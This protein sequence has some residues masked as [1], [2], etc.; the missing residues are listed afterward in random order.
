MDALV[1][2]RG[3]IPTDSMFRYAGNF[4]RTHAQHKANPEDFIVEE[5]P[6]RG[7]ATTVSTKSDFPCREEL[8]AGK[9]RYIAFTLVLLKMT[10]SAGVKAVASALG[11]EPSKITV[12]GNKDRTARTSQMAVVEIDDLDLVRRNSFP[13]ENILRRHGWFIK[14]VRRTDAS[15]SKGQLAGNRFH[16]KLLVPGMDKAALSAYL[17]VRLKHLL[18]V[19]DDKGNVPYI[20]NFFGRQRLGRRQ[21]L[22]GVGHTLI[23]EGL[24][25]GIK[26]FLCEAVEQNDHW[27]ATKL[28]RQLLPM[29][30]DAENLAAKNGGAVAEQ[31]YSFMDMREAMEV[32]VPDP[33]D[34]ERDRSRRRKVP[35]YR[36]A[37][38][39]I[40]HTLAE[41]VAKCKDFK[42]LIENNRSVRDDVSLWVG[43]YQS[44]WANQV[45]GRL[46]DGDIP[47]T[48]LEVGE[49]DGE[50]MIPL[51]FSG[52]PKSVKFYQQVCPEAIPHHIDPVV[53][54]LFLTNF[55]N[56]RGPRRPAFIN[57]NDLEY[58]VHDGE[59]RFK[60]L[61]RSGAYATNFL[62]LLFDLDAE[63]LGASA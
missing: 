32:L 20:P 5:K 27:M 63:V 30:E 42:H 49:H 29:W 35:M 13:D 59:V 60:F 15:L 33:N 8:D 39:Y 41:G 14:D 16:I 46:L 17:D 21:N 23:H 56:K 31:Y 48:M 37:N 22:L 1:Y 54:K 57:V 24:E 62:S 58:S 4:P 40:E 19:F 2:G 52:D 47:R 7:Y 10:T 18:A 53:E 50:L 11:V 12:A 26:R 34:R 38:M 61:L 25:A 51:Y 43:A 28:R 45:L 3:F 55:R 44:Y 36:P 9:G 6:K